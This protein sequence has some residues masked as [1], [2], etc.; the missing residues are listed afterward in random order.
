MQI[1][2]FKGH[3]DPVH[4]VALNASGTKM[5]SGGTDRKVIL[6]NVATGKILKTLTGHKSIVTSVEFSPD[7]KYLISSTI[8]GITKIWDIETGRE[9]MTHF[10]IGSKDW[11]VTTPQGYF[12]GT[13][14]AQ[15]QVFFVKELESYA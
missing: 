6:W 11:L 4:A 5:A 14:D 9:V 1:R 12:N 15:K 2:K 3:T 10:S 7:E 8:D 13:G